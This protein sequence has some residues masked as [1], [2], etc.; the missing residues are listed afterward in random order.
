[1]KDHSQSPKKSIIFLTGFMGS[2][3]STIGPILANTLG[4]NYIDVDQYIEQHEHKRVVDIFAADGE[5]A[6]R[7]MER[8]AL[9]ALSTQHRCVVSLGGGTL[10]NE[11]NFQLITQN[12]ILV[13]LK[14]S[15][16]EILLRVQHRNDRPMLRDADGKPLPLPEMETR[17]LD[18]LSRREPFYSRADIVIPTDHMRVGVTVDEIMKHIRGKIE[19]G[20]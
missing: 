19:K 20:S 14:L 8:T 13:Y 11:D 3:K 1:M 16:A 17:I 5:Q 2:G 7:Q 15:P 9:L 4:F 10:S 12:G 6:F 18:L